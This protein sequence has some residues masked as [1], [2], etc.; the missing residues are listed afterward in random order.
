MGRTV[1]ARIHNLRPTMP[2]LPAT[3]AATGSARERGD[4]SL[5][6]WCKQYVQIL[7]EI[8]A[9]W[10]YTGNPLDYEEYWADGIEPLEFLRDEISYLR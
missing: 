6:E 1:Y 9:E 10:M 2:P 4:M 3:V 5:N 7:K 8:G